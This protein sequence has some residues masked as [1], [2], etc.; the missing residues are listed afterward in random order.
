M[1]TYSIKQIYD[2]A[3]AAGFSHDQATTWTAIALAESGGRV[4]ALNSMGEHSVGLWQINVD[5]HVRS[6]TWGELNDPLINA[7]AAFSISDHGRNLR[8]WTTTHESSKGTAH[9]YRTYLARVEAVTGGHGDWKG[10]DGYRA[11][12]AGSG[13]AAVGV[14]GGGETAGHGVLPVGDAK[15]TAGFGPY[16]TRGG[17][18]HGIDFGVPTGTPVHA[19]RSGTIYAAEWDQSGFGQHIRIDSHDNL[20]EIY[21]H[22]S[23]LAVKNGQQ[24]KAGDIIGYSGSTGRSSGPHLHFEVRQGGKGPDKAVNPQPFL[25]GDG[26]SPTPDADATPDVETVPA[27]G[28]SAPPAVQGA[29]T[30]T[31]H[32]GLTDASEQAHHTD[33]TNAD[34][35]RDG[36]TDGFEVGRVGSDP[37]ASD[38]DH[39]GLSDALEAG[40][41]TDP[42]SLDTDQ[43]GLTDTV[44]V[45]FGTNPLV[46]DAGD[47]LPRTAVPPSAQAASTLVS[48]GSYDQIGAGASPE[49]M[50]DTDHDGLTDAFER[51]AGT[52]YQKA[53]TDNDGL[54]DAY[55]ALESHTDPLSADTDHDGASDALEL[56][57]GTDPGHLAGI[58]GVSG[59][60]QFAENV[61]TPVVDTDHDGLSD[62]YEQ[63]AHL[64][65]HSADTDR[66]GLSDP[67]EVGL[68]TDPTKVD[69]DGDGLTDLFE[70]Q[71][72]RDPLVGG[73]ASDHLADPGLGRGL[74]A[75]EP[76]GTPVV[77]PTHVD[78]HAPP[79]GDHF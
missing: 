31:D 32:D 7:K 19:S 43:D 53:D 24:V 34:T 27:R 44:E 52:S 37:L 61:R 78:L 77:D 75:D 54:T 30:D 8:P 26:V 55:E 39:D 6:N 68:G 45:R 47:G 16:P 5:P 71:I 64:D 40:L 4:R 79:I 48:T 21:G 35:D 38:T 49:S 10:V 72:G 9:D 23:K 56:A 51:L 76:N 14:G 46:A 11:A 58:A 74:G 20:V 60:G 18:H 67:L 12:T 42:S 17:E 65:P 2:A 73:S 28:Q 25:E 13:E 57:R 29:Q 41:G 63:I 33:P 66:D 50:R 69:T 62:R 36:L 3:V 15:V 22:L 70:T 59:V 1:T